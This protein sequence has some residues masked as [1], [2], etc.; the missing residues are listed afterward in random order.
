MS[1][2]GFL[3]IQSAS[4]VPVN[5]L[6]RLHYLRVFLSLLTCEVHFFSLPEH[7]AAADTSGTAGVVALSSS[8]DKTQMTEATVGKT[9]TSIKAKTRNV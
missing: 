4:R 1:Y 5:R 7:S 6:W 9:K 2:W 8:L 3:Q